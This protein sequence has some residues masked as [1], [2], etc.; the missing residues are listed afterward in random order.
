[1]K[2]R[3][4]FLVGL[5]LLAGCGTPKI[6]YKAGM[7]PEGKK[8]DEEACWATA[9]DPSGANPDGTAGAVVTGVATAQDNNAGATAGAALGAGLMSG[10]AQGKALGERYLACMVA[11]GYQP[12][13]LTPAEEQE[14][15]AAATPEARVEAARRVG[16]RRAGL[17]SS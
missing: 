6:H 14:V 16:D 1:M 4:L 11:K 9:K 2:T 10:Y 8:A 12:L 15:R 3:S 5:L 13:E 7:T 17:P